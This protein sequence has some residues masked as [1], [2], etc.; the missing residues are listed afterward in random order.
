M[1][2]SKFC[3]LGEF[4]LHHSFRDGPLRGH[5]AAAAYFQVPAHHTEPSM[6]R[7]GLSLLFSAHTHEAMRVGWEREGN[8]ATL[9]DSLALPPNVK[10]GLLYV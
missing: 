8:V 10:P 4:S 5:S 7:P 9:E 1:H 2:S 3:P 6:Y